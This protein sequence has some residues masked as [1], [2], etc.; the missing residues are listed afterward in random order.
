MTKSAVP[1]RH[2]PSSPFK[3][4]ATPPPRHFELGDRITH[5]EHGLGRVIGVEEGIAVLVDF[6]QMQKRITSPYSKMTVL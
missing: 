2:L 1:R 6:G 5:D 4:P 3:A